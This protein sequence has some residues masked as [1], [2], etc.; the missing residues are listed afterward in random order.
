MLGRKTKTVRLK[1]M[2]PLR[3]AVEV[4]GWMGQ[5]G[6]PEKVADQE[7]LKKWGNVSSRENHCGRGNGN[8]RIPRAGGQRDGRGLKENSRTWGGGGQVRQ[9]LVGLARP[10]TLPWPWRVSSWGLGSDLLSSRI[11][12]AAALT[13]DRRDT[14]E[15]VNLGVICAQ[16]VFEA[17]RWT[18]I[19][20]E[21]SR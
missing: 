8:C 3:W 19:I 17:L 14:R 18:E 15:E 5:E 10:L 20:W 11:V 7:N 2:N 1:R 6:L 4:L 16:V 12:L 21:V 13:R 9:G